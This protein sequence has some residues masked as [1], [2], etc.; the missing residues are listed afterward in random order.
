[1]KNVKNNK[2]SIIKIVITIGLLGPERS[3]AKKTS[4]HQYDSQVTV[5][6]RGQQWQPPWFPLWLVCMCIKKRGY[7]F[8]ESMALHTAHPEVNGPR[9]LKQ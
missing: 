7:N 6:F 2:K 9:T 5:V 8:R 3:L 1:M 4:K